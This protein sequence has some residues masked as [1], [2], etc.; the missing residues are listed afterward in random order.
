MRIPLN[1]IA[2]ATPVADVQHR[3]Y[4][5]RRGADCP[6]RLPGHMFQFRIISVTLGNLETQRFI[7]VLFSFF[8]S[9]PFFRWHAWDIC[10]R[11]AIKHMELLWTWTVNIVFI[12]WGSMLRMEFKSMVAFALI[13]CGNVHKWW[14]YALVSC[15]GGGICGALRVVYRY[16]CRWIMNFVCEMHS[17]VEI[18]HLV[19]NT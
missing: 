2:K 14:S 19:R 16:E 10:E 1:K 12:A 5:A 9:M 15:M 3:N 18:R 11:I 4:S 17:L 13:N 6:V 7:L 8:S